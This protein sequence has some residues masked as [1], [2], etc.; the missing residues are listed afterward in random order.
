MAFWKWQESYSTN[1]KAFDDDHHKL[2]T[3]LNSLYA[4]V[5]ECQ[6]ISQKQPLIEK[7]LAELIDYS[8]YHFET[9]E[10]M[11]LKYEYPDYITHKEEHTQF[12][13]QI[14]QW[15]EQSKDGSLIWTFPLLNFIK[16][17]ISSHVLNTDKQYGPYLNERNVK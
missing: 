1:I 7:A 13:L 11:M 2:I 3:L 9:E 6:N 12:K 17:W 16:D 10:E 4:D 5:Y 15:M 8:C 14:T